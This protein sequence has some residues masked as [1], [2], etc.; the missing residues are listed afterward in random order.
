MKNSIKWK[1]VSEIE[2]K[3]YINQ[4]DIFC[5]WFSNLFNVSV[6]ILLSP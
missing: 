3:E 5:K 1:D 6:F 2:K 4:T